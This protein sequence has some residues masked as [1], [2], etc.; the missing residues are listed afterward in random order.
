MSDVNREGRC[1]TQFTTVHRYV[2]LVHQRGAMKAERRSEVSRKTSLR[3]SHLCQN[4]E[5][6]KLSS[7]RGR[8]QISRQMEEHVQ[9]LFCL[10]E[11]EEP[12]A[13]CNGSCCSGHRKWQEMSLGKLLRVRSRRPLWMP[14]PWSVTVVR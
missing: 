5:M 9:R 8:K 4:Q 1:S 2:R 10:I 6:S 14:R 13:A 12:E 11:S 7:D 3:K